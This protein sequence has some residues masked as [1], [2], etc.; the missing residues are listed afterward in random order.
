MK[1]YGKSA[2]QRT[3]HASLFQGI[4]GINALGSG[5]GNQ[6]GTHDVTL[7]QTYRKIT[8]RNTSPTAFPTCLHS[9]AHGHRFVLG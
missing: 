3:K 4:G 2:T 5:G 6:A 7:H 8:E 1:Y 9:H